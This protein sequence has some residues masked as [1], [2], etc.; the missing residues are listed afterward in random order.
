MAE[1]QLDLAGDVLANEK[2]VITLGKARRLLGKKESGSI[3]DAD[4][5]RVIRMI[6]DVLHMATFASP[7]TNR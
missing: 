4:L 3:S 7:L 6:Y 2:P 5:S 1:Q